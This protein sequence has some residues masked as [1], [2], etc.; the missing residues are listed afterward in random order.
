MPYGMKSSKDIYQKKRD[1][2]FVK[3]KGYFAIVDDMQVYDNNTNH[4]VHLHEAMEGT[5]QAG[6]KLNY[7]KC[8]IKTKSHTFSANVYTPQGVMPDPKKVGAI[9]KM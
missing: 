9:K 6:L 2:E 5:R 8:F 3:C 1:Q 7:H 4:D